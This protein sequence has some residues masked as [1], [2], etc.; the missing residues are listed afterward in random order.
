MEGP[1]SEDLQPS[2]VAP[3]DCVPAA[4]RPQ[5]KDQSSLPFIS[6]VIQGSPQKRTWTSKNCNRKDKNC[7]KRRG[8]ARYQHDVLS[9]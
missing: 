1:S 2:E 8:I 4:I 6:K 7:I 5:L 9:V 3:T